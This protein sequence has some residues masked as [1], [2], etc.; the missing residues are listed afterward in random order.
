[1]RDI[2]KKIGKGL[3]CLTGAGV[4]FI[5]I[6]AIVHAI[7]TPKEKEVSRIRLGEKLKTVEV[8]GQKIAAYVT[9]SGSKTIVL[10]SGLGTASPIADFM[11]LAERF[12]AHY[13]VVTLECFGYGFSDRTVGQRSNAAFINEIRSALKK[14]EIA[15]PYIL[16]PH[17]IS[18][19]Y[20]LYYAIHYPEEV[21]AIIGID[22]S[23]PNQAD[24]AKYAK[25]KMVFWLSWLSPLNSLGIL[26]ALIYLIPGSAGIL[27]AYENNRY[28]DEDQKK[29]IRSANAWNAFNSTIGNEF[30][31]VYPNGKELFGVKYPITLPTLSFLAKDTVEMSKSMVEKN[32]MSKDWLTLHEEVISNPAIQKVEILEGK[33]YLHHTQADKMVELTEDFIATC[34]K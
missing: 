17:S 24:T 9:G 1:M 7:L 18:G 6:S 13:K 33:H 20:S 32:N 28:Y 2:M 12:S 31:S 23:K 21:G 11:P 29:L 15:P 27:K 4:L 26:R 10:L 3:L 19:F 5:T 25:K 14:L 16:M 22:E 34:V 30:N 8:N